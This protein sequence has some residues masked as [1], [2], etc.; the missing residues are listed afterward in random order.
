MGDATGK[1]NKCLAEIKEWMVKNFMKL[2]ESKTELLLIGK[3]LVLKKFNLELT[4]Q[5]GDTNITPTLC[6]GESWKSLG[7]LLDTTLNMERQINSGQDN[8]Q[9]ICL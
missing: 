4:L 6:K 9:P 5:F 3:P 7:V 8:L 2:N 1:I